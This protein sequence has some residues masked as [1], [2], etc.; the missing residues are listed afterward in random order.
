MEHA[1]VVW[2]SLS[3]AS[4]KPVLAIDSMLVAACSR[5]RGPEKNT[6]LTSYR[7]AWQSDSH[8]AHGHR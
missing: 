3:P 6:L 4:W 7:A 8:I 1:I 5:R 2:A